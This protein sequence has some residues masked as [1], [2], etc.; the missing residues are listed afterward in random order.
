M[1]T[2]VQRTRDSFWCVGYDVQLR[3]AQ[4]Q[5]ICSCRYGK[6]EQGDLEESK[7]NHWKHAEVAGRLDKVSSTKRVLPHKQT[8]SS[9]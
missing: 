3:E 6:M 2:L 5:G 7:P 4:Q 8:A 9:L 1:R